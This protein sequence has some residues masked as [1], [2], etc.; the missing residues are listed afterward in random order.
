MRHRSAV[1]VLV[2]TLVV[3]GVM[4]AVLA[5]APGA[6]GPTAPTATAPT[7]TAP[8]ATAPTPA[9]SPA[10]PTATR[11]PAA[12]DLPLAGA[13][14]AVDPGHNRDN[15][16]SDQ[17][18]RPVDAGGFTK[19]CNSTGAVASDGYTE[20]RFTWELA[21]ALAGELRA[22]GA[23][24]P[25]TRSGDAGWGP[26][27]DARG[28]FGGEQGADLMLSLHADGSHGRGDAG[29]HVIRP[30]HLPGWTDDIAA[31]SAD[32]ALAV[33]EALVA[34]GFRTSTYRGTDGVDVRT[35]LGT[36]NWADVPTVVVETHNMHDPADAALLRTEAAQQRMAQA[37]ADAVVRYLTDGPPVAGR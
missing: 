17:T 31:D 6:T 20:S 18:R 24:V 27:V 9:P 10:R 28:R 32:L 23:E 21:T 36:L 12:P 34:A 3:A 11:T 13:V 26:C 5:A 22:L 29:F 4:A 25:M 7:A 14:V 2:L 33:R 30:G 15:A 19:D 8:T 35:D 1:V 16:Q 37:L